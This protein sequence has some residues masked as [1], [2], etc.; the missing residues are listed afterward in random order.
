MHHTQQSHQSNNRN[1]GSGQTS[2]KPKFVAKGHDSR[3]QD[4]QFNKTPIQVIL[5]S[6]NVVSGVIIARDRY[7][8]TLLDSQTS[9][10]VTFFKHAM[11]GFGKEPAP[12]TLS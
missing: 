9:E 11:E 3:L 2:G 12:K 5:M 7:T 6:G 4:F 8:I 10:E 1:H